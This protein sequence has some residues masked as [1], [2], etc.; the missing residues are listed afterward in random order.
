ME[1][2]NSVS[3]ATSNGDSAKFVLKEGLENSTDSFIELLPESKTSEEEYS[4]TFLR[5]KQWVLLQRVEANIRLKFVLVPL[6]QRSCED[7]G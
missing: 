7:T 2:R 4:S 3:E 6:L 1:I 5:P